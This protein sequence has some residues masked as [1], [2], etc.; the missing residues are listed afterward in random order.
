M[1]L[2]TLF[3]KRIAFPALF[4]IVFCAGTTKAQEKALSYAI[5]K[6]GESIGSM[7]IVQIKEGSK[8]SYKLESQIE[9][10]FVFTFTAKGIEEAVYDNGVLIYS[11]V[12]Q[13]LN[14]KEKLNKQTKL[15]GNKYI[16]TDKGSKKQL[17]NTAI[18]YNMIC[19]YNNE[20]SPDTK[21][22]S[23]KFQGFLI[24]QKV[25]DHHYK[26]SFP[27]GNAN[28]YYY[29]NGIC[30]RIEVDHTFYTA[31]MELQQ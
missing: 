5:K 2:K 27:D 14:G 31:T 4:F 30:T 24:I 17:C 29:V 11:S 16:V 9:A 22:F 12:Y 1:H 10:K 18:S 3:M 15:N 19:L 23:D 28:E 7:R 26:I 8:V 6:G 20:P 21:L 13:K 25:A